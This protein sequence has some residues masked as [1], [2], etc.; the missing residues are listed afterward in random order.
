MPLLI[1]V[2]FIAD[3]LSVAFVFVGYHLWREWDTYHNTAFDDYAQRCLYGTIAMLLYI[4]FGKFLIKRLLSKSK[5]G[6]DEPHLFKTK[7]QESLKRP[8]GSVI[9]IE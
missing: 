4:F 2:F 7:K 9:N 6:E 1:L 5:K 3:L 8:D